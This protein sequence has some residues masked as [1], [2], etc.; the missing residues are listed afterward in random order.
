MFKNCLSYLFEFLPQ[1]APLLIKAGT[2]EILLDDSL[3]I[4]QKAKAAGVEVE[5]TVWNG[6]FHV[7]HMFPFFAETR[8]AVEEIARFF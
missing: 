2:D 8:E 6:M 3:R 7:F 5:L 4:A 1:P